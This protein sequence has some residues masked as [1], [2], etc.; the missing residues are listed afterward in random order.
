M[1]KVIL[2]DDEILVRQAIGQNIDWNA[3]GMELVKDCANGQEAV[4]YLQCN[5]VDIVLT[6]IFMP[7]MDGLELSK[8]IYE[9]HP[10]VMVVIFSGYG[11]FKYAQKA[12][13]YKV[14]EYLLKPVTPKEL[15]ECM[16]NIKKK[17]DKKH[18]EEEKIQKLEDVYT[19]RT[20]N[21]SILISNE[22]SA[23]VKG[24]QDTSVCLVNLEKYGVELIGSHFRVAV[25]DIDPYAD[26][27]ESSFYEKK[28][29]ALMSFVVENISDE[30]VRLEECGLAYSSKDGRVCVLLYTNKPR[31][32]EKR[33]ATIFRDIT[34]NVLEIMGLHILV[35]VGNYVEQ[36]DDLFQSYENALLM[37]EYQY[38]K[39]IDFYF[40]YENCKSQLEASLDLSQYLKKIIQGLKNQ[41]A[42]VYKKELDSLHREMKSLYVER[43]K[44]ISYLHQVVLWAYDILVEVCGEAVADKEERDVVINKVINSSSLVK[45]MSIVETYYDQIFVRISDMKQSSGTKL[46][47]LAMAYLQEHFDENDLSLNTIC[48]YLNVSTSHFS[49]VFKEATGETFMES[50]VKLRMEKAKQL[51]SETS[52]KN[53]EIADRVGYSDPH[54]FN[55]AFKKATGMTPKAY[56]KDNR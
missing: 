50:L 4:E 39:G 46:A 41:N 3:V 51:L 22:L 45:G 20:R 55:I 35:G 47:N 52:L 6:D 2:V 7:F 14:Q 8:Y 10:D 19:T 17:L 40:D 28:E 5:Q 27:N 31:E 36:L 24:T 9:N 23:L 26:G 49:N 44:A 43:S 12:M 42:E 11:E 16:R 34:R 1:Y 32:F 15:I 29:C 56:A 53:Y 30:I 37:W 21:Q 18:L 54:Y 25:L 13:L 33:I 38:V 48:S